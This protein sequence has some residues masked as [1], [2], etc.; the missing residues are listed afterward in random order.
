MAHMLADSCVSATDR[1]GGAAAE[2]A[3]GGCSED[4]Q[5]RRGVTTSAFRL[6]LTLLLTLGIFI[7]EAINKI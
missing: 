2:Q 3:A 4:S 7:L 6:L 1:S 5:I